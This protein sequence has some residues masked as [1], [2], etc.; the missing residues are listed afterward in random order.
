MELFHVEA[1]RLASVRSRVAIR[2]VSNVGHVRQ[3]QHFLPSPED[4]VPI[5]DV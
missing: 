5:Q 3:Y 2:Q 1:M 4:G